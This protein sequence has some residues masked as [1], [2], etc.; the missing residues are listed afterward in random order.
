MHNISFIS[1][2]MRSC[3]HKVVL[4]R[5]NVVMLMKFLSQEVA[6]LPRLVP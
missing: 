4:Y 6:F 5:A 1:Y 3:L 2:F